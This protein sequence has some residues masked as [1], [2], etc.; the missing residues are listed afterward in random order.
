M[1]NTT[2]EQALEYNQCEEAVKKLNDFLSRE[3]QPEEEDGV[4]KHL[5]ACRGCFAKFAFEETLLRTIR[6]KAEHTSAPDTLRHRIL[7]L[8]HQDV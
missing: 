3:L 2:N 8:L 7:R 5:A 4:Q 6:E 1:E